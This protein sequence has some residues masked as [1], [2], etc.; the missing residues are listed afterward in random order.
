MKI[1]PQLR[2]RKWGYFLERRSGDGDRVNF[3]PIP[4]SIPARG[5]IYVPI[6]VPIPI[7]DGDFSPM[8]GRA[9]MGVGIPR[10][11][12]IPTLNQSNLT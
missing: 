2:T 1:F 11:I 6:S 7:G 12:A 3:R 10:P 8:R 5:F 4:V 9:P